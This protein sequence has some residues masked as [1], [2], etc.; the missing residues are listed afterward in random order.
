[1]DKVGF[2]SNDH[3]IW[4]N[5]SPDVELIEPRIVASID[6][7]W[8]VFGKQMD[9]PPQSHSLLLINH[10]EHAF[11][12][13]IH[14][15]DNY[16]YFVSQVFGVVFG[17]RLFALPHVR[18][19]NSVAITI[20]RRPTKC[21]KVDDEYPNIQRTELPRKD[22][23]FIYLA[24]IFNWTTEPASLFNHT[25]PYEKLRVCLE[26]TA[27][28][29]DETR[30]R[31]SLNRRWIGWNTWNQHLSDLRRNKSVNM[32]ANE[33]PKSKPR[34]SEEKKKSQMATAKICATSKS[35]ASTIP[36]SIISAHL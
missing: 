33:Q 14:T 2:M 31:C 8:L 25:M 1:M 22:R 15:S 16:A 5:Q 13:K 26:Y 27:Q 21:F 11:A 29:L 32:T 10:G 35:K 18:T 24:P 12:F 30:V 28:P 6:K 19:R 3:F 34:T 23:L 20:F 7:N 36:K 9:R 4:T 17:R